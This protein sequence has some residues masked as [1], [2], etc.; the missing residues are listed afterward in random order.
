MRR[1]S[2]S[3][4]SVVVAE[5][6]SAKIRPSGT[7]AASRAARCTV[8]SW[9]AVTAASAGYGQH[10]TRLLLRDRAAVGYTVCSST[11]GWTEANRGH[12]L[13]TD[14]IQW[15]TTPS[16]EVLTPAEVAELPMERDTSAGSRQVTRIRLG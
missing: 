2:S 16:D 7:P 4:P 6:V 11:P 13:T 3:R 1:A 9:S 15:H 8:R 12:A 10:E 5:A 14:L